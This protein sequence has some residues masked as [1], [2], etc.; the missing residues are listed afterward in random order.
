MGV[1]QMA[2]V[3][4]TSILSVA[5]IST[6]LCAGSEAVRS[7]VWKNFKLK[8]SAKE[9]LPYLAFTGVLG[10]FTYLGVIQDN[11]FNACWLAFMGAMLL[12][13]LLSRL[14]LSSCL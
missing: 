6:L 10:T 5:G 3:L 2:D 13:F 11:D 8:L 9:I 12:P 1:G 7:Q 14:G 4:S